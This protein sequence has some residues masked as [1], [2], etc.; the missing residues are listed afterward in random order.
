MH[1]LHSCIGIRWMFSYS[2]TVTPMHGHHT[3]NSEH[4]GNWQCGLGLLLLCRLVV[5]STMDLIKNTKHIKHI[6]TWNMCKPDIYFRV[7][8]R[9]G[10]DRSLE[11][12]ALARRWLR[13]NTMKRKAGKSPRW[14]WSH[15]TPFQWDFSLG[16]Q[17][18]PQKNDLMFF[19]KCD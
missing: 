7:I 9:C 2:I 19:V 6:N 14:S 13:K 16:V 15:K 11:G 17:L 5:Y 18:Y 12:A 1:F 3:F 10:Q 8:V 4:I